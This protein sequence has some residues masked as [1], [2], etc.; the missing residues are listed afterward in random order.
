MTFAGRR[1]ARPVHD[2]GT[3]SHSDSQCPKLSQNDYGPEKKS[4][5][6][7]AS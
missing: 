5:G 1:L 6:G 7:E 2:A 3:A 4:H